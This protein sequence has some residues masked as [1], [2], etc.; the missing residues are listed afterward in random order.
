MLLIASPWWVDD[1]PAR[2]VA[3]LVSARLVAYLGVL[4]IGLWRDAPWTRWLIVLVAC[5]VCLLG[6]YFALAE[7]TWIRRW[8]LGVRAAIVLAGTIW[9]LYYRRPVVDYYAAN[10]AR[11]RGR[12]GG[13]A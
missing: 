6:A 13:R 9:Y 2:R 3:L 7:P 10:T 4:S 1:F 12:N 11:R 5:P 8:Q